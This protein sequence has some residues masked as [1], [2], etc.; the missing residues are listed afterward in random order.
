MGVMK[1]M[2]SEDMHVPFPYVQGQQF[3]VR[4]HI[5]P[6]PTPLKPGC[7]L[8]SDSGRLEREKLHPV[9]RCLL[10]PPLPGSDG[11]LKVDFKITRP[12]RVGSNHHRTQL[13]VVNIVKTHVPAK[14]L[15]EGKTLVAKVYDPLYAA[16]EDNYVN[17]F[18]VADKNYTH[19]T[20][21]YRKLAD[22]QGS[23]IPRYYGSFSLEIPTKRQQPRY[24]RLIL[25]EFIPGSS[26]LDIDPGNL[27][28]SHRQLIMKSII[29]FTT[30]LY[31]RDMVHQDLFQRNILVIN[32]GSDE[33]MVVFIDFGD[34]RF[35]RTIYAEPELEA[36]AFPGTYVSP[37]LKWH[38]AHGRTSEFKNWIDWDWQS[39]LEAE[40]GHTR[41]TITKE[42]QD[43]F[44]PDDLLNPPPIEELYFKGDDWFNPDDWSK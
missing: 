7:C 26:M 15:H 4:S 13:V 34:M 9:D 40:Y 31:T 32:A 23:L 33:Q 36:R 2:S 3:T 8:E 35:T 29:D 39:W 25:I 19:E 42:M 24:V 37:L 18:L 20:A 12:L 28:Q 44:L 17:P 6:P 1:S 16:D 10:H 21:A 41:A 43:E 5:P 30:L 27:S 38:K 14:D 22:V 11:V